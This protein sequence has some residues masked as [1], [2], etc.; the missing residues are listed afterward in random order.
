MSKP[1]A[2]CLS[3]QNL[4]KKLRILQADYDFE[5]KKLNEDR[6]TEKALYELS[7]NK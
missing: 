4:N 6:S 3:C 7:T 5:I 2:E 1:V